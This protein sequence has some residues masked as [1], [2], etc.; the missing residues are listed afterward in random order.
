[1]ES[2]V[3]EGGDPWSRYGRV[4]YS[5]PKPHRHYCTVDKEP[6]DHDD[7]ECYDAGIVLS[8]AHRIWRLPCPDCAAQR[9]RA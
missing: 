1:M 9:E 8:N 6:F 7:P 5:H 3:V 2:R 4:E